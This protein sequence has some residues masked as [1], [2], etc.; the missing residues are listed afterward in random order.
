M[1]T[2]H[3]NKINLRD[4]KALYGLTRVGYFTKEQMKDNLKIT[5]NRTESML[6]DKLIE[7]KIYKYKNQE[8]IAYKLTDRGFKFLRTNIKGELKESLNLSDKRLYISSSPQH[9]VYLAE[10]YLQLDWREQQTW[11]SEGE[12]R[13]QFKEHLESLKEQGEIAKYN[14]LQEMLYLKSISMPD[15]SYTSIAGDVEVIEIVGKYTQEMIQA[16][17]NYCTEIGCNSTFYKL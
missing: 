16:K 15:G 12:M 11:K 14:Q 1:E 7:E 13:D 17:V 6:K 8:H 5:N 2:K 3:I 9:D 4:L 10:K